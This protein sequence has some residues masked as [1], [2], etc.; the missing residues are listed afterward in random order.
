MRYRYT[1]DR[2][3]RPIVDGSMPEEKPA[4][5]FA[6]RL[7]RREYGRTAS[8]VTLRANSWARDNSVTNYEA[9]IGYSSGDR[10]YSGKNIQF[11]VYREEI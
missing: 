4:Q 11:V 7:A 10:T 6:D 8:A 9:F 5:V 3:N 2:G 1:T